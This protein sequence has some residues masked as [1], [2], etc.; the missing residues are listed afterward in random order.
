MVTYFEFK[1]KSLKW[2]KGWLLCSQYSQP[3]QK[4]IVFTLPKWL[5]LYNLNKYEYFHKM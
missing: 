3:T 1:E 2:S 4:F 5:Y